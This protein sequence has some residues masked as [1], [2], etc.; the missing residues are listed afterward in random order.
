MIETPIEGPEP[1]WKPKRSNGAGPILFLLDCIANLQS[2]QWTRN[3]PQNIRRVVIGDDGTS[4]P[5]TTN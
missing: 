1:A 2:R 3:C 5:E 4:G